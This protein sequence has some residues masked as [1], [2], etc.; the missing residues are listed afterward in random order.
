[1]FPWK[2]VFNRHVFQILISD[3]FVKKNIFNCFY[4][5]QLFFAYLLGFSY[6]GPV[7]TPYFT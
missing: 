7:Q 2:P 4:I 3:V 1:M 6:L 5:F